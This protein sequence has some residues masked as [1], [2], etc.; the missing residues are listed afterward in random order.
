MTPF[1]F[2][3]FS[4][5]W[6]GGFYFEINENRL[7][8]DILRKVCQFLYGGLGGWVLTHDWKL[9]IA[10]SILF[11]IGEKP[12]WTPLIDELSRLKPRKDHLFLRMALRGFV[13]GFGCTCLGYFNPNLFVFSFMAIVFP[14]SAYIGYKQDR[15]NQHATMELMRGFLFGLPVILLAY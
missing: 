13:Y 9:S 14:I 10:C 4:R 11:W 12:N 2:A 5:I 3:C 6:G 15:F 8:Y 1:L 7:P